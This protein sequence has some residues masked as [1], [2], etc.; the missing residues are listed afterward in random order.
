MSVKLHIPF[1]RQIS[2]ILIFLFCLLFLISSV[3]GFLLY[4]RNSQVNNLVN[5]QIPKIE[6][7]NKV[8]LLLQNN[9]SL[10]AA[11][12][13]S[14][15]IDDLSN[16]FQE[17]QS[18]TDKISTLYLHQNAKINTLKI[19]IN[20]VNET[21]KRIS[22]NNNVNESLKLTAIDQIDTLNKILIKE[23][24]D[25]TREQSSLRR[26]VDNS[27]AYVY[28]GQANAYIDSIKT[29]IELNQIKELLDNASFELI[30]LNLSVP[31]E[32]LE[33][34]TDKIDLSMQKWVS[35]LTSIRTDL[36]IKNRIEVLDNF[37]NTEERVLS[38]WHSHLR[39][40]NELFERMKLI[41]DQLNTLSINENSNVLSNEKINV[42]PPVIDKISKKLGF[43]ISPELF[44]KILI[45]AFILSLLLIV[46]LLLKIQSKLKKHGDNTVKLCEGLLLSSES[47]NDLDNFV[48]SS[49]HLKMLSLF[50]ILK[51]QN[52]MTI[53]SHKLYKIIVKHQHLLLLT[54]VLFIGNIFL[55]NYI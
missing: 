45:V 18:N 13:K 27:G 46:Y 47:T 29:V 41:N 51:C 25:K 44:N 42:L 11:L 33:E 34:L 24:E 55:K 40:A 54:I 2:G 9:S 14:K 30:K 16:T 21:L 26:L 19:E 31:I 28:A 23:I 4:Q 37:L 53:N 50:N 20:N 1:Y 12:S 49:E 32:H 38:K 39:L 22:G 52:T 43:D 6:F 35:I 10:T 3:A 17:I 48:Q 7:S 5:N 36:E 15:S 8:N